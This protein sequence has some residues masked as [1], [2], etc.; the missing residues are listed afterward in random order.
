MN[1][2]ELIDNCRIHLNTAEAS[3]NCGDHKDYCRAMSDL[4]DL[5]MVELVGGAPNEAQTKIENTR[6]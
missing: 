5:L 2:Y 6:Y 4:L 1:E 3:M